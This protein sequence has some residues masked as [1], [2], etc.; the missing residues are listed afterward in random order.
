MMFCSAHRESRGDAG[1]HFEEP[2]EDT[3]KLPNTRPDQVPE[4]RSRGSFSPNSSRAGGEIII[5]MKGRHGT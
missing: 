1:G 3:H 5:K 4:S 2:D